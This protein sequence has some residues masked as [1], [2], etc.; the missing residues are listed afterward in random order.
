MPPAAFREGSLKRAACVRAPSV[1]TS[2]PAG[3]VDCSVR[4]AWTLLRQT[5]RCATGR[6]AE[7]ETVRID[8]RFVTR[9]QDGGMLAIGQRPL[10]RPRQPRRMQVETCGRIGVSRL[11]GDQDGGM[12]TKLGFVCGQ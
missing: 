3:R 5:P 4:S 6:V 2:L 1:G 9:N 10:Q 7:D 12:L 11:A 8:L